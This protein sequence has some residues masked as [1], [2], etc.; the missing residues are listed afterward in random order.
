[1]TSKNKKKA[2][3]FGLLKKK[4]T[5]VF[6]FKFWG[7]ALFLLLALVSVSNASYA[8]VFNCGDN[9]ATA[10]ARCF[11][12]TFIH[13]LTENTAWCWGSLEADGVDNDAAAVG[14][15]C[16]EKANSGRI[17]GN[18]KYCNR[19]ETAKPYCKARDGKLILDMGVGE[20]IVNANSGWD[21]KIREGGVK[22]RYKVY[23]SNDL[24]HWMYVGTGCGTSEFSLHGVNEN[25]KYRY[26]KIK[27][28]GND[29]CNGQDLPK[30]NYGADISWVFARAIST[31]GPAQ[32][33]TPG[34]TQTQSCGVSNVGA[35]RLGSQTRICQGNSQWGAYGSCQGAI[36][37]T[38]ELCNGIDDDCDGQIDNSINC[39][40]PS[41]N[42]PDQ[43]VDE[44][45]GFNNNLV[46]I[47]QYAFD[48]NTPDN[49]LTFSIIAQSNSGIVDCVLDSNRYI[50]C[51]TREDQNGYNDVTVRMTDGSDVVIDI[52]R[53]NVLPINDIPVVIFEEGSVCEG[54]TTTFNAKIFDVEGDVNVLWDFGDGST[55][56]GMTAKH[57]YLNKG[58]YTLTITATDTNNV[59]TTI[60]QTIE[61]RNCDVHNIEI[62]SAFVDDYF[63]IKAGDNIDVYV[64]VKN[65]GNVNE[66]IKLRARIEE[67]G[68]T[69]E[70][71]VNFDLN[72]KAGRWNLLGLKVPYNAKK[73][74]YVVKVTA[75]TSSETIIEYMTFKVE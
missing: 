47:W 13:S 74:E 1:M 42:I 66:K 71:M 62:S 14:A 10:D 16:T 17:V 58:Q 57:K 15:H 56:N 11:A 61:A 45:S 75:Y 60:S 8:A 2:S 12:N 59:A 30:D 36:N 48:P 50:D 38:T 41:M 18:G 34:Q 22:E 28:N 9:T 20:E 67:L 68:L 3:G 39:Q 32:L 5:N 65:L 6:T 44:D 31:T 53:V 24:S 19:Q 63:K 49:Q 29:R 4:I 69:S 43:T 52:F 72:D 25:E 73:G 51:T 40:Q 21:I 23:V 35:C 33:C 7:I 55:A 37:P 46:D 70:D 26:V 27:A 64:K 54:E